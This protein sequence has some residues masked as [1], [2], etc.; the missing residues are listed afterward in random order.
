VLIAA[1]ANCQLLSKQASA[2]F[3]LISQ[4]WHWLLEDKHLPES[5]AVQLETPAK[6]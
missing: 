5:T 3:T 2:N 6:L 4:V 1:D